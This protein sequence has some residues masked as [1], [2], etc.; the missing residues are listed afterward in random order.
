MWR[1][2][3][4][5]IA[6]AVAA[7]ACGGG[8]ETPPPSDAEAEVFAET[9]ARV[10]P[11]ARYLF[12]LHGRIIE[13]QGVRPTHPEFGV[14]EYEAILRAFADRGFV[15]ISEARPAGTD[16]SE[17]A[18]KVESQVDALIDAGVPPEQVTV[19]G[20]SKGGGIAILASSKLANERLNFVFIASCGPWYASRP[21]IVPRGRLLGIREASDDLA[22]PCEALFA[23]APGD[24][25]RSE[26]LLELG[27]GHG[28]FYRP[29]PAWI[30]PVVD[31]ALAPG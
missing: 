5:A 13:D 23:R 29:Q 21:E 6:F 27:G 31:W 18:R 19:V 3:R 24:G 25:E 26:I 28:A 14:Y 7:G 15:V 22:G 8:A 30:E 1:L 9:S 20:F 4:F 11:A 16:G 2:S 12:Y 10:E 17:Y